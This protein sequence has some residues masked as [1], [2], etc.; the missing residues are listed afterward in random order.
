MRSFFVISLIVLLGCSPRVIRCSAY[1]DV[2][3]TEQTY[4]IEGTL[5]T[6]TSYCGGVDIGDEIYE[7]Q[8]ERPYS[9]TVYVREGEVNNSK[10]KIIDSVSTDAEGNFH[11]DLKP[12]KY[13]L[14][15]AN[16][17]SESIIDDLLKY[18]GEDTSV[19]EECLR[20]W[21]KNG[22][23]KIE[24]IDSNIT[25]LKYNFHQDCFVPFAIPCI[26]YH[27]PYPP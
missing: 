24:V 11:F 8:K 4:S 2:S 9:A 17:K 27:G 18:D 15:T 26:G 14:F 23:F 6:S 20:G 1:D 21:W 25:N 22:L 13:I 3:K 12:G 7:Y 5:T 16:F 10:C 19:D